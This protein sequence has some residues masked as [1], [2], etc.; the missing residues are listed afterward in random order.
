MK[1]THKPSNKAVNKN[2]NTPFFKAPADKAKNLKKDFFF[3]NVI[4]REVAKK[5]DSKAE[6]NN[7][8]DDQD[9]KSKCKKLIRKYIG[10]EWGRELKLEL[11]KVAPFNIEKFRRVAHSKIGV[12]E[13]QE[14][15]DEG[16]YVFC[17]FKAV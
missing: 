13:Y 5:T 12:V 17:C 4:Q 14:F 1:T 9:E 2:S 6:K 8:G 11:E 3:N 7:N 15:K 16:E 10:E